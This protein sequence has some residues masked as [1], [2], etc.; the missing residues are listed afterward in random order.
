M[1]RAWSTVCAIRRTPTGPKVSLAGPT[2]SNSLH[3]HHALDEYCFFYT[4]ATK[5]RVLGE[6]ML[7]LFG[8]RIFG[9]RRD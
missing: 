4:L 3:P 8:V 6:L 7:P 2:R 5:Q 1:N 9:D